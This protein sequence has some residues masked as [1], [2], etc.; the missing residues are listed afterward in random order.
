MAASSSAGTDGLTKVLCLVG[1][2]PEAAH[3][4]PI[5]SSPTCAAIEIVT[6]SFTEAQFACRPAHPRRHSHQWVLVSLQSCAVITTT[7]F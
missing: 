3:R 4:A 1:I 5:L 6:A 2:F 7:Q